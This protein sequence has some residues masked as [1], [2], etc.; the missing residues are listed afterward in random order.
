[1]LAFFRFLAGTLLLIAVI[2]AVYDGT[3]SLNANKMVTTSLFEHWQMLA[4]T[5]LSNTQG[6]VQRIHPMAWEMG[7]KRVLQLPTWGVFAVVGFGLAYAG[8]RRRRTNVF[9]N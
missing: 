6:A 8:R 9:A 5:L 2:A 4:P 1:M 7:A 3:R